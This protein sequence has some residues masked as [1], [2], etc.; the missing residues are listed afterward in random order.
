M[1]FQSQQWKHQNNVW[2]LLKFNNTGTRKISFWYHYCYLWINSSHCSGF[3]FDN[4]E[5]TNAGWKNDLI[6]CFCLLVDFFL[7]NIH[8]FW[9]Y[10]SDKFFS[11]KETLLEIEQWQRKSIF[12]M[13]SQW[14]EL[15]FPNVI[16]TFV[17][18]AP[19]L[20]PLEI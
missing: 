19:F 20:Y 6:W 12:L 7:V 14:F 15:E 5:Q 1:F 4:F 9:I 17:P 10:L 8:F 16:N 11:V 13:E 18:N 2:N 3:S